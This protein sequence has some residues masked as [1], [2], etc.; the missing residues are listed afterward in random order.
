MGLVDRST[1]EASGTAAQGS[2]RKWSPELLIA[3]ALRWGGLL[4]LCAAVAICPLAIV[5]EHRRELQLSALLDAQTDLI[6]SIGALNQLGQHLK[7]AGDGD[8]PLP[9]LADILAAEHLLGRLSPELRGSDAS[10]PGDDL[11]AG[12]RCPRLLEALEHPAPDGAVARQ[13]WREGLEDCRASLEGRLLELRSQISVAR[14]SAS[15]EHRRAVV[16]LC[17]ASLLVGGTLGWIGRR[18]LRG[19]GT[20]RGLLRRIRKENQ[21]LESILGSLGCGVI[22]A[23]PT[24]KFLHFNSAAQALVGRS[25]PDSSDPTSWSEEFGVFYPDEKTPFPAE[26]LP[27]ARAL[28]GISTDDQELFIRNPGR[29][30]G[31]HLQV[32]GRPVRDPFGALAGG[33]VAFRDTTEAREAQ[34]TLEGILEA[35]PD[36]M[37][38]V[39]ASGRISFI[40]L[41]GEAL[42]GRERAAV[43]GRPASELLPQLLDSVAR[44]PEAASPGGR[45]SVTGAGPRE[46]LATRLDG[47]RFPAEISVSPL[48]TR[49]GR[50]HIVVV[51]DISQRKRLEEDL[52]LNMRQLAASNAGLKSFCY[53][54]S[55]D[56]KAPLRSIDGFSQILLEEAGN[57][58]DE[59][60]RNALARISASTREMTQL[61]DDMLRLSR[62]SLHDMRSETVDL[63]EVAR[64]EL[65]S[66][67]E[68]EPGREVQVEIEE[69][70]LVTG[71]QGLL[72]SLIQNL[73][74]NAWKFT[75]KTPGARIRLGKEAEG[76]YF[77]RDNGAGFP[78]DKATRLFETFQRLHASSDF[79][80]TGVGLAIARRIVERHGGRIW[81][82]GSPGQ[83][84]VFRFTLGSGAMVPSTSSAC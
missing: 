67:R 59:E 28:K 74:G 31:V 55:H 69:G 45:G 54:V 50:L 83:G 73:L 23:S 17:G 30:E 53:S 77:V 34:K 82:E 62:A 19:G 46:I 4:A 44:S 15:V 43:L 57:A 13:R 48:G 7:A 39:E 36:A 56:L 84:S 8:A 3:T 52:S 75:G 81:A 61:I 41:R 10:F 65:A 79:A 14:Q 60:S 9:P 11:V 22:M 25:P 6:D 29:P 1:A 40:N 16:G 2:G 72:R 51:R 64:R 24:G 66:L 42:F 71:D 21:F 70:L 12:C 5:W 18:L 47:T 20:S 78:A 49:R 58:L 32:T 63:S 76:V 26:D 80:G 38:I 33:V 35:A 37:V 68:S 27:L